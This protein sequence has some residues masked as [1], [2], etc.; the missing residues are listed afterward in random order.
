VENRITGLLA[1]TQ[2]EPGRRW[3]EDEASLLA[4]VASSS[5]GVI[6]QARLRIEAQEK[7]RLELENRQLE[8]EHKRIEREL[9]T[10]RDIQMSLVP[11]EALRVG[12]WEVL[13][14]VVPARQVG[15]DSF[16]YFALEGGRLAVAIADVSGKGVPAA[17][18]MG[19][20]QAKI[21]AHC[22]GQAPLEQAVAGVNRS[23][24]AR[25]PAGKF[26]TLFYAE[27]DPVAGRLRYC[28]AGHNPPLLRRLNGTLELLQDGGLPLGLFADAR[29]VGGET[30][31][32]PG[33]ALLLYSDG[34]PEA[35][36]THDQEFGDERLA[37]WWGARAEVA[38]AGVVRDLIAEVERFRGSAAQSDDVTAVVVA[39]TAT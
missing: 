1:V 38:P 19:S 39:A 33:D 30:R 20:V 32:E 27:V 24:A 2:A 36:D 16:D 22:T 11:E 29:Y 4:I 3:S 6:E 23:V 7:Q 31:F 34:I 35:F 9:D 26:I 37:A 14:R 13:G 8:A 25:V 15:G 21:R 28:N 12:P 17:I 5:A 10:A 18:L